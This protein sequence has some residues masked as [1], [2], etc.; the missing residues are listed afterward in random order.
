MKLIDSLVLECGCDTC[1][2]EL[3]LEDPDDDFA[4]ATLSFSYDRRKERLII[5]DGAPEGRGLE[6]DDADRKELLEELH[7]RM[8]YR[9]EVVR[10]M[11][12]RP[13]Q[14]CHERFGKTW[15]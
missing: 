2:G 14:M 1:S 6:L 11:E 3:I 9:R 15:N 8:S 7:E 4:W 13:V 5:E 12:T 10:D